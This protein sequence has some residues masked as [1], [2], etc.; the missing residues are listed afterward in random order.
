MKARYRYQRSIPTNKRCSHCPGRG[1]YR[2]DGEGSVSYFLRLHEPLSIPC[3][4]TRSLAF[5][6]SP[7]LLPLAWCILNDDIRAIAW[8]TYRLMAGAAAT[9][10]YC[11]MPSGLGKKGSLPDEHLAI[12][13]FLTN[14]NTI[15][16]G[17]SLPDGSG[18]FYQP[19]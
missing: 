11:W 18:G 17:N 19:S 5:E 9:V 12:S 3:E 4:N 2:R 7:L 10:T 15:S 1:Q 14:D 6:M 13:D 8:S 16:P